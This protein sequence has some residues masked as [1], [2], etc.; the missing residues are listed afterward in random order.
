MLSCQSN[1]DDCCI[2]LES[3]IFISIQDENGTDLLDPNQDEGIDYNLIKVFYTNE[4]G[5]NIEVNNPNLDNPKGFRFITPSMDNSD[6][7]KIQIFLNSEHLGTDNNSYTYIQ[8]TPIDTD[9]IK[10]HFT[11]KNNNLIADKIWI[12][13]QV[14][15]GYNDPKLIVITK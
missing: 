13:N 7:Y 15:W 14:K 1:D 2:V 4:E 11:E 12:N 5:T 8:W 6:L 3:D 10:T 9:E